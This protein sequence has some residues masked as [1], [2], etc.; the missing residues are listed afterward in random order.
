MLT[1]VEKDYLISLI[2]T[3]K[4]QGYKHYMAHTVTENN[5]DYDI[6]VYF[7]KNDIVAINDNYFDIGTNALKILI[8]SSS[9]SNYD[10]VDRDNVSSFNGNVTIPEY[11][12]IYTD[13]KAEYSISSLCVNP[14][15]TLDYGF[16]QID[17]VLLFLVCIIFS[18][19]FI[20]DLLNIGGR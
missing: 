2:N 16:R 13:A 7:S 18:Y 19:V 10:S 9:R 1:Q 5:N 3:Y 15:I 8:N 12:F 14:D 4:K 20:K 11:E 6:C 17:L